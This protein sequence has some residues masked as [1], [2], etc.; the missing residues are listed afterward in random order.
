MRVDFNKEDGSLSYIYY[1]QFK[2]TGI[3]VSLVSLASPV[4]QVTLVSLV[5]KVS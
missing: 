3:M 1:N 4:S 2:V 5:S